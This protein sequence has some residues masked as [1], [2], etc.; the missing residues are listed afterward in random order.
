ML[1]RLQNLARIMI[2]ASSHIS[3]RSGQ[4]ETDLVGME[5]LERSVHDAYFAA[6]PYSFRSQLKSGG[7]P[8]H[9]KM[10]VKLRM[11]EK[12]N[13]LSQ[14]RSDSDQRLTVKFLVNWCSAMM[15]DLR[16]YGTGSNHTRQQ[17]LA[18][19]AL[20]PNILADEKKWDEQVE[21]QRVAEG[22]AVAYCVH[23]TVHPETQYD[24]VPAMAV[25]KEKCWTPGKNEV[26]N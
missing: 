6:V 23:P 15:N 1:L 5:E 4:S 16:A 13:W 12:V 9:D 7:N 25:H 10:A 24:T 19:R 8:A 26:I 2:G 17:L 14:E 22:G 11:N 20:N 3:V 21:A 18:M